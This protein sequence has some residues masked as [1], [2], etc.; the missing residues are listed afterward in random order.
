MILTPKDLGE[1]Q[2]KFDNMHIPGN[3]G[4]TRGELRSL[5]AHID[6]LEAFLTQAD[7]DDLFGPEGWRVAFA[8]WHRDVGA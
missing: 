1:I 3:V 4:P 6:A 7:A 8:G 2:G 5:F